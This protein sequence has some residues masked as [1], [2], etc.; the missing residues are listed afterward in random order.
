MENSYY[1]IDHENRYEIIGGMKIMSP[2]G[3]IE[4]QTAIGNLF[5]IFNSYLRKHKNG[6]VFFDSLDVHF[7][8][9]EVYMP[10]LKVVCDTSIL[11]HNDTI[12]GAPELVVE[13]LSKSTMKFDVG[14][15]KEIY[16]KY[17][18]K[19]Y[20]I[21]NIWIKSIEVYHLN[22]GKFILD[23]VYQLYSEN[24]WNQ[25]TDEQRARAKFEIKV[26]IFDDLIVD[27]NEVFEWID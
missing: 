22:E 20:W 17:G 11:R 2:S 9:K 13:V 26:S 6:R 18:V 24:E 25:L 8:D 19:E 23:D 5:F 12:Y 21:V 14:R 4:H 3:T 7:E 16:E 27:V 15:K 10:D 1:D